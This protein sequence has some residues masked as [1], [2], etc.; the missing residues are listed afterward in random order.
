MRS[1]WSADRLA[2][3]S[4]IGF[5]VLF[6]VSFYTA[7]KPPSVSAANT[8]WVRYFVDN[9]RDTLAGG[10][11]LGLAVML[12]I[13][14]MGSL[15]AVLRTSGEQRLAAVAFGGGIVTAATASV[16]AAVQAAL[17][18]RIAYD[19]PDTVKGFVDLAFGLQTLISLPIAVL[20]GATAIAAWRSGAFPRWWA[21]TSGFASIV[22]VTGGGALAQS[23]FYTPDG[24]WA[25][26]TL[27]VFLV[28]MLVTSGWL[29][30][31]TH[32]APAAA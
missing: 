12:F 8:D 6:V 7:P 13:W 17:A 20:I 28:W 31:R 2:A 16:I 14:F 30:W 23:G 25:F 27:V 15:G 3:T 18:Y 21:G 4:G 22:M 24:A 26:V 11:I 5:V 9:H 29:V 32:A 1:R 19:A 10:L